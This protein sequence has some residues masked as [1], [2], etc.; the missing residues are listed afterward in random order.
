MIFANWLLLPRWMILLVYLLLL[1]GDLFSSNAYEQCSNNNNN[2]DDTRVCPTDNTCCSGGCIPKDL[3]SLHATC[4]SDDDKSTGCA[5]G[6]TCNNV[7]TATEGLRSQKFCAAGS[8]V[9]DP[10]VQ[11]LPRYRLCRT[12]KIRQVHGLPVDNNNNEEDA[13]FLYYSSHG[14]LLLT[15]N[16]NNNNNNTTFANIRMI[17]LVIH[18]ALRNADDYFCTATA[19]VQLQQ[20]QQKSMIHPEEA[21]LIV[22]PRFPVA[23]DTDI[24]YH[25]SGSLLLWKEDGS[26][27]WRYGANAISARNMTSSFEAMDRLMT[28]LLDETR[29]PQVQQITMIGHSSGGQFVQRY[30][31]MTSVWDYRIRAIVSNPSSYAY[32]FPYR[33]VDHE[34]KIPVPEDCL[35]YNQ[36]RWGL[37]MPDDDTHDVPY[38]VQKVV[39]QL[40]IDTLLQRFSSR[41]VTYLAGSR[42][43]CPV[44]AGTSSDDDEPTKLWCDSHELETACGDMWQ[45]R[46]RWERHIHYLLSLDRLGVNYREFIVP[47]VGHDH[48]LIFP[49]QK[50]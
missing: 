35:N 50:D 38:Y 3:G 30:S 34:W 23:S 46:H 10:F 47:G 49:V 6:Y 22:A 14:D 9:K 48:S 36:W 37:E 40:G 19:V 33:F 13:R 5:V 11:R 20:R 15:M 39:Q 17:L 44:S 26:G 25:G 21:V 32:L 45:G 29:F 24:N 31:L 16:N 28:V 18:G 43:I 41:Q 8:S 7:T 4:C 42:D 12:D 1:H 27:P 2:N